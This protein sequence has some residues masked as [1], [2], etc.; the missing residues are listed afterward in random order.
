[1]ML[2]TQPTHLFVFDLWVTGVYLMSVS[3]CDKY[4]T[5]W[6]NEMMPKTT[7]KS[8]MLGHSFVL[9]DSK[10]GSCYLHLI[11]IKIIWI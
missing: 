3:L 11:F 10:K 9:S 7:L 5:F 2:N 8:V 1:M 6:L 4:P